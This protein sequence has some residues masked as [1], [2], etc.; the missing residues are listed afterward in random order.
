MVNS[1]RAGGLNVPVTPKPTL[2]DLCA[3][4][5]RFLHCL[6]RADRDTLIEL[7]ERVCSGRDASRAA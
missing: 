1:R 3:A 2:D 7:H 6:E 5:A 4:L